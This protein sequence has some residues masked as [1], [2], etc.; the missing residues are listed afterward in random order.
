MQKIEYSAQ[1]SIMNRLPYN[2]GDTV[3]HHVAGG[4]GFRISLFLV[5]IF[6]L[7]MQGYMQSVP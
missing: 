7:T 3:S 1:P 4:C 6:S 2:N 5:F